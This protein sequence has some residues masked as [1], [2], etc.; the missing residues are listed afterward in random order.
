MQRVPGHREDNR[1]RKKCLTTEPAAT[2]SWKDELVAADRVKTL[3][4]GD[5]R[6]RCT[7]VDQVLGRPA[8]KDGQSQLILDTETSSQCSSG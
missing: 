6:I 2:M 3:T 5:I 8:L 4:A 1:K 7:A